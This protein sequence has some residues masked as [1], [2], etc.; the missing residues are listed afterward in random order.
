MGSIDH[1]TIDSVFLN[2][3]SMTQPSMESAEQ[4]LLLPLEAE[5]SAAQFEI[6]LK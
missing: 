5:A 3:G 4:A 2:G 1:R 6:T